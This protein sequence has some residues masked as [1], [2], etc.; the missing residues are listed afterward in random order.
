VTATLAS[1]RLRRLAE[2]ARERTEARLERCELCSEPI[3]PEH[4]HV[5]DLST[6]ELR[7]SCRACALLFDREGSRAGHFK[8]VGD[9]RLSLDGFVLDD[10]R[11]AQI[12][13]PV[14]I[15]FFVRSSLDG[16]VR[17]RYPSPAGATAAGAD[18]TPWLAAVE[19]DNPAL[20][21]MADD[22]EAL[23]VDRVRGRR[24]QWI[25]PLDDAYRL[26]ALVRTH[27]RGITGGTQMWREL[28]S[29]YDELDR[30]A[31]RGAGGAGGA[32]SS[33]EPPSGGREEETWPS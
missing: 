13:I 16:R 21:A 3:P 15:A 4:R 5:L 20:A 24:R 31:R 19:A 23:L 6:G 10:E 12:G 30:T 18:A 11:W 17:A 22:T 2:Q 25:V 29:F 8:T 1:S 26:V 32:G 9:R 7:C 14:D 33:D 27:W 28:D